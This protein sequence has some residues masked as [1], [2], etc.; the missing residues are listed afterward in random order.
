V[1]YPRSRA[2]LVEELARGRIADFAP[3]LLPR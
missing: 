2:A 3:E 1:H